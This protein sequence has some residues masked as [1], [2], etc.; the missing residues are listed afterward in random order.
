MIHD[1]SSLKFIYEQLFFLLLLAPTISAFG[2]QQMM[3]PDRYND[4]TKQLKSAKALRTVGTVITMVGLVACLIGESMVLGN[5]D[6]N[7]TSNES[8]LDFG[9]TLGQTGLVVAAAGL[10]I[11]LVSRSNVK[12]IK[13]A[14]QQQELSALPS[15]HNKLTQLGL[16]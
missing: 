14:I 10:P 13:L 15:K 12:K 16:I 5:M 4:F 3:T 6:F 7:S 8:A 9:D 2:Q 11:L 1:S